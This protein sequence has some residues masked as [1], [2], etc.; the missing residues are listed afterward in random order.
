M[1]A[2]LSIIHNGRRMLFESEDFTL[3]FRIGKI[4]RKLIKIHSY[5]NGFI[6]FETEEMIQYANLNELLNCL[7]VE[8]DI[9]K[10]ELVV[11]E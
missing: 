11:K 10:Y 6:T 1:I 8:H 7:G 2:Y 4:G 3:R 5:I 9:S